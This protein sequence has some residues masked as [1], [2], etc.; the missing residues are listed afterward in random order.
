M[1]NS[2]K[3]RLLLLVVLGSLVSCS[4]NDTLSFTEEKVIP[5][6]QDSFAVIYGQLI[7]KTTHESTLGVPYLANLITDE[8]SSLPPTISFSYQNS[9][10]ATF[11]SDTGE[12][13][14][15]DV[16]PKNRYAIVLIYGPGNIQVVKESN[17]QD[18]LVISVTAGES[19][20]LG[21]LKVEE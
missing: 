11:D 14:F 16:D 9:I 13:Y 2:F 10:S 8:D 3:L 17:N 19:F 1:R 7:E 20:N 12:F 5:T 18:P 6:P 4:Q 21:I 15:V